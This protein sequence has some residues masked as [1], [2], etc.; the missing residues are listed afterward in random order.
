MSLALNV[1]T[2][3]GVYAVLLGAGISMASGIKT[4]W[5]IVQDLVGKVATLHDPDTPGAGAAAAADPE[6][7]W[8]EQFSEPLGYS[9]LLAEA[10]PTPA[11]RQAI[12][13][14]YFEPDDGDDVGKQPTAAHRSLANW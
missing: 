14:G 4:G 1:Q 5:G 3:P 7:W 11:A 10:A 6:T 2:C 13:A 12:L 9:R 8:R